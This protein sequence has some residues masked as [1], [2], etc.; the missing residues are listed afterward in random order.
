MFTVTN[1]VCSVM[2]D[3][4][5]CGSLYFD[6]YIPVVT[7][8]SDIRDP[9]RYDLLFTLHDYCYR[10]RYC[11]VVPHAL[12]VVGTRVRLFRLRLVVPLYS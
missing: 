8:H 11:S 1:V 2:I 5:C 10:L 9:L 4:R 6:C 3:V 12:F 7:F